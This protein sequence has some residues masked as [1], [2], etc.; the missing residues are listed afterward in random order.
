MQSFD[1]PHIGAA[2]GISFVIGGDFPINR[3]VETDESLGTRHTID[4]LNLIVEQ[5]HQML[6]VTGIQLDKHGV[7]AGGEV[8][9]HNLGDFLKLRHYIAVHGT[10]LEIDTDVGAGGIAQ[11]FGID[12]V[13]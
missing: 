3:V 7:G 13:A 6:V 11:Y 12:M 9:F 8:T 10:S 1:R 4:H 2:E 5:I